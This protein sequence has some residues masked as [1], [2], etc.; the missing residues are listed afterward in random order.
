MINHV[1]QEADC[2]LRLVGENI[3]KGFYLNSL[4]TH[5]HNFTCCVCLYV[6]GTRAVT[7][8]TG[9][10]G[11]LGHPAKPAASAT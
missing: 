2:I 7:K 11:G 10:F 4:F 6:T 8:A 9:S 1:E 5:L 3:E